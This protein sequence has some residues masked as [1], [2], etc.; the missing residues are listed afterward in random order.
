M[1]LSERAPHTLAAWANT[2]G[3]L[4]A[5][6]ILNAPAVVL[7]DPGAAAA[8]IRNSKSPD[9]VTKVPSIYEALELGTRPQL[10]NILTSADDAYWRAVRQGVAPCFSISNLKQ[11]RSGASAGHEQ[12]QRASAAACTAAAGGFVSVRCLRPQSAAARRRHAAR[13]AQA[14]PWI[15]TLCD[16]AVAAVAA[17]SG[18]LDVVDLSKRFTS[19]I[20]G[21]MLFADD[22]RGMDMG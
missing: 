18:C 6:R 2:Y 13:A 8:L 16:K 17:S 4:Y 12:L 11:V 20:M 9:Y 5:L 19:D 15:L 1:L 21:Q 10:H 3:P 7:S 14:F 22:L